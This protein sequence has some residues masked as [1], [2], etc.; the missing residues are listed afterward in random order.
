M[1]SVSVYNKE[2]KE[3]EKIDYKDSVFAA[4]GNEN[5]CHNEVVFQLAF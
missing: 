3:V 5:L 1:A 2:G 4:P